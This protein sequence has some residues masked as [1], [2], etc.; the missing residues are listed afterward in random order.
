MQL[1]EAMKSSKKCSFNNL[2]GAFVTTAGKFGDDISKKELLE[3]S[4]L[5]IDGCA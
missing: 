2:G 5:G 1:F 4:E 3:A